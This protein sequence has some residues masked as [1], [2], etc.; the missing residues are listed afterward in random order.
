MVGFVSEK[1]KYFTFGAWF[2]VEV[3][4]AWAQRPGPNL[5]LQYISLSLKA[6]WARFSEK[7]KAGSSFNLK[8]FIGK[9]L[10]LKAGSREIWAGLGSSGLNTQSSISAW[11]KKFGLVKLCWAK[12]TLEPV[13]KIAI[14]AF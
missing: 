8:A 1:K 3:E 2:V 9:K 4:R 10:R 11:A 14:G 13:L 5:G 6:R 7:L 12:M